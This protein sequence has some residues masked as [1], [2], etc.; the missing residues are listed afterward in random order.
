MAIRP[1]IEKIREKIIEKGGK[2]AEDNVSENQ[3]IIISL[4][5]SKKTLKEI[6][7]LVKKD[8]IGLSRNVWILHAIQQ[9]MNK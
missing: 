7:E 2:V 3:W 8:P 5:I 4:R 6:D 1:K 9:K